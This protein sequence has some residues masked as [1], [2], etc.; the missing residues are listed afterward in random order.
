M[1]KSIIETVSK[2]GGALTPICVLI[3]FLTIPLCV[4]I[5]HQESKGREI[6]LRAQQLVARPLLFALRVRGKHFPWLLKLKEKLSKPRD[7]NIE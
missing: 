4:Y 1:V 7:E 6:P 5:Q 2:L 3:A